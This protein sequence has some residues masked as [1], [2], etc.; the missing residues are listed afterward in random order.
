MAAVRPISE[1]GPYAAI[2]SAPT[3]NAALPLM[4]RMST[5]MAVS[6]GMPRKEN[7]GPARV[8]RVSMAPEERSMDTAVKSMTNV[9]MREKSSFNPSFPPS[10]SSS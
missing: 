8:P 2:K 3:A 9:G 1:S 10:K 5:S 6:G 4:G 7:T